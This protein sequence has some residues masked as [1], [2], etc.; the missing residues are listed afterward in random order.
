[1]TATSLIR[2]L[3]DIESRMALMH[4]LS[5]NSQTT[6]VVDFDAL[7]DFDYLK[8]A[9]ELWLHSYEIL[10]TR[11]VTTGSGF[12][13]HAT[14]LAAGDICRQLELT[15]DYDLQQATTLCLNTVLAA[16]KT[17]LAVV[18]MQD[19]SG[20]KSHLALTFHHAIVDGLSIATL[21]E[22]LLDYYVQVTRRQGRLQVNK[23]P[24]GPEL[25]QFISPLTQVAESEAPAQESLTPSWPVEESAP[26]VN[27]QTGYLET[28]FDQKVLAPLK[29][30]AKEQNSTLNTLLT[31]AFC[32]AV[33]GLQQKNEIT[34]LSAVSMR[35][36]LQAPI[37]EEEIGCYIRV[38]PHKI[39]VASSLAEFA[40]GYRQQLSKGIKLLARDSGELNLAL[41]RQGAKGLN[42]VSVF[43]HDVAM[44][45]HGQLNLT[46]Q[47]DGFNIVGYR[48]MANRNGGV[49]AIALH[50]ASLDQKMSCAFSYSTPLLSSHTAEE[51]QALFEQNI[52]RML[53]SNQGEKYEKAI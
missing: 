6:S 1:M 47:Y 50:I 27:R 30:L 2:P 18:L 31:Y 33:A 29:Q 3:G 20:Q 40:P 7:L 13:L 36:R 37:S 44:T 10:S 48:N 9:V 53:L 26:V 5:G 32:R 14:K 8:V 22:S 42:D 38:Y 41:M 15:R 17:V 45:N 24:V 28:S 19:S 4:E 16:E 21:V 34:C 51:I 25:E 23:R 43:S 46:Q 35:S 12:E 11:V 52:Q 49:F 39:S